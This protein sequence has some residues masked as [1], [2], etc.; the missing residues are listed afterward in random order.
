M[1]A[2]LVRLICRGIDGR[3][4]LE[5]GFEVLHSEFVEGREICLT[6]N[7]GDRRVL[8]R[9]PFEVLREVS[10]RTRASDI[11]LEALRQAH[12]ASIER[13]RP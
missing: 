12:V 13:L 10:P 11:T 9:I 8:L 5:G 4:L 6:L 2:Q 3:L 7:D 1:N